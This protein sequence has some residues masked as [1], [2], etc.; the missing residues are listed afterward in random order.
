MGHR[1]TKIYTKTGDDGKT[2][3]EVGKRILKSHIRLE[4]IGTVDEL[5][6]FI[7]FIL[8]HNFNDQSVR[9]CLTKIQQELFNL[10]GELC[11]PYYPAITDE[12]IIELEKIIDTWNASLPPLKEF[13]MPGGNMK[14]AACHM[15]RT[16]CRRAERCAVALH[17]EETLRSEILKYLNRLSDVLFVAARV[18]AHE[19][20]SEEVLWDHTRNKT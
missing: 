14:S 17:T 2:S 4:T 20:H 3:L 8:A 18:L 9:N 10:G 11:P 6:S 12:K 5:N 1:L 13:I 16:V 19:A 7:G 15:A